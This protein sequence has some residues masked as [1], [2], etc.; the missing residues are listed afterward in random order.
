CPKYLF[1][2]I[3]NRQWRV[4]VKQGTADARGVRCRGARTKEKPATITV[5]GFMICLPAFR[6]SRLLDGDPSVRHVIL[7]LKLFLFSLP[8]PRS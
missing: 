8:G 7:R 5:M 6:F 4:F 2:S 3:E 1:V